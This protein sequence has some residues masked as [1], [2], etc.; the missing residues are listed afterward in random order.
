RLSS[1]YDPATG[2][3]LPISDPVLRPIG[4][5]PPTAFNQQ[6]GFLD[7]D[8]NKFNNFTLNIAWLESTLNRGLFPT[9][10]GAQSLSLEVT[11]PGSDLNYYRIRYYKEHYFPLV[12]EW[13][14]RS[15]LDLGY[16]DGY[17]GTEQLP[18]FQ[19][20]YAGGQGTVRGF[21]RSKLGPRSTFPQAYATSYSTYLKDENGNIV[22][23][24]DGSPG[25]DTTSP[26][27]Y[28]LKQAMAADGSAIVD[29]HGLPVL[30]A[31]LA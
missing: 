8:G 2:T 11:I 1:S 18:F 27:S 20:F 31:E 10:G 30:R 16:G 29:A 13:I 6:L 4:D 24:P 25:R 5:L 21:E 19:N 12:G 7:R 28:T 17:G 23:G 26:L 14:I 3:F 22:L 15:R 9:A